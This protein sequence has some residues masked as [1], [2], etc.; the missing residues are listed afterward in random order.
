MDKQYSVLLSLYYKEKPE[1]LRESLDS[2][3]GQTVV[4]DDV[5]LVEDGKVG[6][7]LECVV[8]EYEGRYPQLHVVRFEENRGL[9][10]ALNDGLRHC[11]HG[12]V[13]RMDTDDIAKPHRMER[14]LEF[15]QGHPEI[16]VVGAWIEEFIDDVGNVVSLRKLPENS[17]EIFVFGK[18]RNPLN[19]P[20]VMFRKQDVLKAGGYQPFPLFE[21][22]YLWVR[23]LNGGFRF[24]NIQESLLF[25]RTSPA[26]YN[27]RGGWKYAM[28]EAGFVLT[29]HRMGYASLLTTVMNL[30]RRMPVRIM[31][32][33]IRNLVYHLI[34]RK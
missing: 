17:D 15:M 34:I 1:Y 33:K 27:R 26:M 18:K 23:M 9:G 24:H 4:S 2:V 6:D 11:K 20:T 7:A 14:Q 8:R 10:H 13:A 22:Y 19:H 21:D 31:P 28:D 25:F 30:L 29:M 16:S 5:V 3:F 12:L 32:N